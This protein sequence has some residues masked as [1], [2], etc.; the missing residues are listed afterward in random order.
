MILMRHFVIFMICMRHAPQ[1]AFKGHMR[2][3]QHACSFCCWCCHHDMSCACQAE[4]ILQISKRQLE[5]K[6]SA[7]LPRILSLPMH[8][9]QTLK[10][11]PTV[12]SSSAPPLLT[13]CFLL[14][15]IH[16]LS[17]PFQTHTHKRNGKPDPRP[18]THCFLLLARIS[19]AVSWSSVSNLLSCLQQQCSGCR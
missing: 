12:A 6:A 5:Q 14:F 18:L 17:P 13:H 10:N 15:T 4:W 2:D 1:C 7:A 16:L 8:T 19:E 11:Q 3:A 9:G